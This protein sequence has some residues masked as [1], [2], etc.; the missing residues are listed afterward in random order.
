MSGSDADLLET[1]AIVHGAGYAPDLAHSGFH[2]TQTLQRVKGEL[3]FVPTKTG[4]SECTVPLPGICVRALVTHLAQQQREQAEAAAWMESGLVFTSTI[5][6]PIEP[7]NLRRSWYALRK[8]IGHQETRFHDLRRS[9]VSMLL[10]IG[11]SP[12]IVTRIIGHSDTRVTMASTR[13]PR[14][15][16]NGK[17]ST[18]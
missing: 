3:Q 18:S 1:A 6:T 5:G 2:L 10:D 7:D 9:C 17:P 13:M 12:H 11:A 8:A 14:W 16:N 15:R 4:T